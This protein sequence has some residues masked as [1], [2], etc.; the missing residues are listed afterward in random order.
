MDLIRFLNNSTLY[1]TKIKVLSNSPK[2]V[3]LS[4]ETLPD[5][6]VYLNGFE[7]INEN[8]GKVM[9][10]FE[11]EKYLYKLENDTTIIL[12]DTEKDVFVEPKAK[13]T[14]NIY[15]GGSLEGEKVQEVYNYDELEIPMVVTEYGYKFVKWEPEI[16]TEGE[17]ERNI[18]FNAVVE[19]KN[20]YFHCSGGGYLDGEMKQFVEDYSEL[21]PPSPIADKDF[22]F[23]GWMPE[24]PE[25]GAVETTEFYAVFESNIPDRLS[26]VENDLT[27][28]QLGLVENFDFTLATAEEVTDLQL[29][30]VELY[31]MFLLQIAE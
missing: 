30:M 5:K 23:V 9:A 28:T 29:A 16:P 6:D 4:F 15:N 11:E 10:S 21:T 31:N 12:T 27:D 18:T 14:F 1:R 7:L 24:I 22:K 2:R 13:V 20:I 26:Y 25:E 8:N 3:S 19:D 17:V